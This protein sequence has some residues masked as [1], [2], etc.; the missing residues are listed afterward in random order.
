VTGPLDEGRHAYIR[1][2]DGGARVYSPKPWRE[3]THA[4]RMT[5]K[6]LAAIEQW[7]ERL[8][9]KKRSERRS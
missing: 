5:I 2:S 8:Y 4:E 9:A 6:E 3:L 7:Q 1:V